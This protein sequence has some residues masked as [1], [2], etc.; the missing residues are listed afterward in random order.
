MP[1]SRIACIDVPALP[2]QLLLQR[3]P[4]WRPFP[5]VVVKDD[6][7][8]GVILWANARARSQRILP[9]MTFAAARSLANDLRAAV[10]EPHIIDEAVSRLHLRLCNFSPRVEPSSSEPGVFWVDPSGMTPLYGSLEQW[11]HALADDLRSAGWVA[12][13]VVGFHRYR[14]YAL[15]RTRGGR[16]RPWV[17]HDPHVE[18]RS[19]AK[20]PLQSLGIAP[21]LR[22]QLMVLGVHTLGGFLRL[23]AAE[24]PTRFGPEAARLHARASDP[25]TPMQPRTLED[26]VTAELQLEPP[27]NDHTRL[28]FGLKG[29]LHR[30]MDDLARRHQAMSV[31]HLQLELDHADSQDQYIEPA[32]PT[33]DVVSLL[34]LVRL[35]LESLSLPAAVEGVQIRLEGVGATTEQLALFRTQSRRDLD[36]ANRA[37]ARLRALYGPEAVT[38][39][40][41]RAAHLPEA[42]FTWEPVQRI[43]FPKAS[44]P[45][46][47]L[48]LCRRIL[49]RPLPLPPRPRHEPE[50]WLGRRGS[51]TGL[52]GPYRVSGGWWVRTVE[53]DYYFAHTSHGEALWIYYDRPRRRWYLH[54]HVD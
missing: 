37:I 14:T 30:L 28:L 32:A 18:S 23:P 11:G 29:K 10:I 4:D 42:S 44:R 2:L 19:A 51:I 35:R 34:E 26:P 38:C 48:P 8:Q 17:L 40:H 7:P 24:L 50:T 33:L 6:R 9:G 12:H 36:A 31:L 53:R 47:A 16:R 13:V 15:A 54:G 45:P 5:T 21:R 3:E 1:L 39:A 20:T 49:P 46:G 41:A 27:D 25:W 52:D 43:G 22:D